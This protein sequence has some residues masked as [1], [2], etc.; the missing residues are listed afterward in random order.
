[1]DTDDIAEEDFQ[2]IRIPD[3]AIEECKKYT[4]ELTRR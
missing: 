2:A 4:L 1:M 3:L